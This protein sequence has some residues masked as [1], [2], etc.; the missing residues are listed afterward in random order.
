MPIL[1]AKIVLRSGRRVETRKV[2]DESLYKTTTEGVA[3]M[4]LQVLAQNDNSSNDFDDSYYLRDLLSALG[5]IDN[6]KMMP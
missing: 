5:R 6:H 3:K 2:F 1:D 4:L